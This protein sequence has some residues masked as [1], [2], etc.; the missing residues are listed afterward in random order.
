LLRKLLRFRMKFVSL[1]IASL[2]ES[3]G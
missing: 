3:S 1:S 2:R